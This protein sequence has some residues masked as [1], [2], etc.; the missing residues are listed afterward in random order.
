MSIPAGGLPACPTHHG[1]TVL[2][3]PSA[4]VVPRSDFW[5]GGGGGG[6]AS[7]SPPLSPSLPH[8]SAGS[9]PARCVHGAPGGAAHGKGSVGTN[10]ADE[11]VDR[12]IGEGLRGWG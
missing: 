8:T 10:G 12:E 4:R 1:L 3:P 11:K 5:G 2:S 9:P 7:A 6:G